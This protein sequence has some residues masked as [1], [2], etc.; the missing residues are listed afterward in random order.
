MKDFAMAG[1][2]FIAM[3]ILAVACFELGKLEQKDKQ[4]VK[5]IDPIQ[6]EVNIDKQC[7]AWMFKTNM[8]DVK[9]HV[10]GSKK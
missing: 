7:V 8:K 1:V 3:S 5:I 9:R 2:L 10:C 4:A 6:T